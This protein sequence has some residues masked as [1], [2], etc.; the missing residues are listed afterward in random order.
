MD[1]TTIYLD[2]GCRWQWACGNAFFSGRWVA[3]G[4]PLYWGARAV[5]AVSMRTHLARPVRPLLSVRRFL[6]RS[7]WRRQSRPSLVFLLALAAASI[8]AT[9]TVTIIVTGTAS[10]KG[11][12]GDGA[13]SRKCPPG[14]T[15]VKVTPLELK[16]K[17]K[18]GFH[19]CEADIPLKAKNCTGGFLEFTKLEMYE[20]DRRSLVLEFSPASIVPPGATWK[21]QVPWTT[22]GEVEAVVYFRPSGGSDTDAARAQVKVVNRALDDAKKSCERCSGTWG[23]YGINQ[24]E[25]CNCKSPDADKTCY[26][27]DE[28]K[29]QCLF[30]QY[31]GRG[32]EV[33]KCSDHERLSGCLE[34]VAKGASKFPVR[35]PP[36][37][38]LPTCL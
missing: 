17:C 6:Q 5:Y 8:T 13:E 32:R 36:P 4:L 23:K 11:K 9:A 34:I 24:N 37:R 19:E 26:D 28:C 30:M 35:L 7:A 33:G 16:L 15:T 18:D 2:K 3:L 22:A 20:H 14:E 31:D 21:E 10:A 27:G 25:G 12:G 1:M 38:K 29:G